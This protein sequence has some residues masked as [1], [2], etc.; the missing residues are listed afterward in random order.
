MIDPRR[1]SRLIR[2]DGVAIPIALTVLMVVLA[3]T[4]GA[5]LVATATNSHTNRDDN[6]KAAL[7]AAE[8]GLRTATFRLNMFLPDGSHCPTNP[9]STVSGATNLCAQDGPEDLGNGE[10]F[11]YWVGG[12]LSTGQ[13]C[14]GVPVTTTT[15]QAINQRCITAL[16]TMNG[17]NA[18]TQIRV[19]SYTARALFSVSGLIGLNE[20][21]VANNAIING[22]GGTNG[23]LTIN[24][25]AT[26]SSSELGPNGSMSVGQNASGG[27]VTRESAAQGPIGL[28]LPSFG[29]SATVNDNNRVASC[30]PAPPSGSNVDACSGVTYTDTT[31]T[32]R[33]VS[34]NNGASLTLGGGVYNFCNFTTQNN[35]TINVPAGVYTTIYIDSPYDPNSAGD[36]GT[37]CAAGSGNFI[38]GNGVTVN[39]LGGDPTQLKIFVYGNP[40]SPGSTPPKV[41]WNNNGVSYA[42]IVA[43]FSEV[44][45]QNNGAFYGAV[46][47]YNTNVLNNMTFYWDSRDASLTTGQQ[48]LYYRTAWK[49]CTALGFVA[50][51]PTAG[52]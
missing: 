19:A 28:A 16:G 44:D 7:E 45:L 3:L 46:G 40:T 4:A 33:E 27:T 23:L 11:S 6:S 22:Q 29:N 1:R 21:S 30:V 8:A 17:I 26:L 32:P 42:T 31:A 20:L 13:S 2:E 34:L 10:Q 48:D 39:T 43:P 25:N 9:S 14:A 38:L 12:A 5:V 36:T 49:Q 15:N 51:N 41:V 24:N 18:V 47:G 37:G 50:S 52:C 35:A